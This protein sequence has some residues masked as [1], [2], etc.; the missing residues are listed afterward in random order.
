MSAAAVERPGETLDE[1]TLRTVIEARHRYV[2]T[3]T[4]GR[5]TGFLDREAV[6]LAV[7]RSAL[8]QT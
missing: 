6:A 2:P 3:T 7:A 1:P 4:E 5:V 8:A